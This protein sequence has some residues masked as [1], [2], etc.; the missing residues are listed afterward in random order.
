MLHYLG[1]DAVEI[2]KNDATWCHTDVWDVKGVARLSMRVRGRQICVAVAEVPDRHPS[3]ATIAV[4]A[5]HVVASQ[6][7]PVP[8]YWLTWLLWTIPSPLAPLALL[9]RN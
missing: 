5:D 6:A 7:T 1:T 9:V 3:E 4:V 8:Y 2:A